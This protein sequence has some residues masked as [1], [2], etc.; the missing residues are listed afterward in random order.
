MPCSLMSI[1]RDLYTGIQT[2]CYIWFKELRQVVKDEG[3]FMFFIVVP[4]M[5]P[6]LYSWIYNNEAIHEVPVC[7]VDQSHSGLS[8]ELVRMCDASSDVHVAYY[9]QDLDEAKSLVSRQLVQGIYLIPSD[10]ETRLLRMEQ[11]TVSVYCDMSLMLAYKAVFQTVQGVTQVMGSRL[12]TKI[13]GNIT[14]REEEISSLPLDYGDVAL[15]NPQG[16]YGSSVLPAVLM[17]IL[18]QTLVLGIGLS[19][20]TSREANP[21]RNLIPVADM[22]YNH[23]LPIVLGKFMC[24]A[25]IYAVMGTWLSAAVP[26]LFHFPQLATWPTLLAMMT[27]YVIACIFFGMVMSCMVKYRENVML[28][29]VFI[30]VPL[31]FMTGV[32]WP[33]NNIPGMWQGVSWLFPSTFGARAFV[34]LNSMGATLNDISTEYR[35]LWIQAIAYFVLAISLYR[36]QIYRVHRAAH[37]R[38]LFLQQ[39]YAAMKNKLVSKVKGN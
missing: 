14:V 27:P 9:A 25:M 4:I 37:E 30:S 1:F 10:F 38:H 15:F 35:I 19:A 34:R 3:V 32:S 26:R 36:Y 33:Q 8:R 31:L 29:M 28:L 20:G 23:P 13:A 12:K 5:Y 7:V 17:L 11:A 24:Y 2:T 39:K 6:L 21:H 22:R 16:G 18:Q